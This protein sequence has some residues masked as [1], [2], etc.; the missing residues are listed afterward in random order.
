MHIPRGHDQA[1]EWG[2]F[3]IATAGRMLERQSALAKGFLLAPIL[4]PLTIFLGDSRRYSLGEEEISMVEV[5]E[6]RVSTCLED[7]HKLIIAIGTDPTLIASTVEGEII[8]PFL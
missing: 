7:L 4:E 3:A 6:A 1:E 2:R 5:D 8:L